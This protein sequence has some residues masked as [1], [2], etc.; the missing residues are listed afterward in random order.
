MKILVVNDDSI[1]APGIELLAKAAMEFGDVWVVAPA[2]QCS[3]M[4][5]K[6]TLR[7]TLTVEKVE[8]FPVSV[9]GAYKVGGTPVDCVKVALDYIL[10]EKPDWVF[11]G[12]NNGY[13]VGFDIAY[14]GTLGAAF[15]AVRHEIPAMAFSIAHDSHLPYAQPHL[16]QVMGELLGTGAKQGE[17]W[18]V[19]FPAM[20]R[21]LKGTLRNRP[22]A[23]I[24]LYREKYI[25]TQLPDGN[26][27][28]TN[29]GIPTPDEKIPEGTDAWAVRNGYIAIG[30]VNGFVL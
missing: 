25:E 14:S 2:E 3:A 1:S 8:E 29:Q 11:S 7:E 10:E 13:N 20:K 15:E 17:V 12:I 9:Q 6:L 26:V 28:L 23:N 24:S 18:N 16:T 30:K 27:V 19:N 22:V 5:Q 4:S 21:G